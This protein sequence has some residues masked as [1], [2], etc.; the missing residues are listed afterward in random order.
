M[1]YEKESW[2]ICPSCYGKTRTRVRINTVLANFSL[3]CPRCKQETVVN[4]ENMNITIV[5]EPNAMMLS[6]TKHPII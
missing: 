1:D 2:L 3:Y 4:V 6:P 5:K